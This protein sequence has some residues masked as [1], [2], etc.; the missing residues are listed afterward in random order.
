M[1]FLYRLLAGL[2]ACILL[3][4]A[5]IA[6]ASAAMPDATLTFAVVYTDGERPSEDLEHTVFALRDDAG[7]Y[8]IAEPEQ[9]G[10]YRCTGWTDDLEDTTAL[11]AG[12]DGAISVTNLSAGEYGLLQTHGIEGYDLLRESTIHLEEGQTNQVTVRIPP[13]LELPDLY[14]THRIWAL[15]LLG[16]GLLI[17]IFAFVA[18]ARNA[19]R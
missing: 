6:P 13:E 4:A 3:G 1:R 15:A 10:V 5:M 9:E 17:L 14:P 18:R 8:L 19:R 16:V 7:K 12:E 11:V 2:G